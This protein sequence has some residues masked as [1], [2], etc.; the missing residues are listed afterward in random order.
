[1]SSEL[2]RILAELWSGLQVP[3]SM[4]MPLGAART[5]W[6]ELK[7]L[8]KLQ[9]WV[10]AEDVNLAIAKYLNPHY[11]T[12]EEASINCAAGK[13]DWSELYTDGEE[14]GVWCLHCGVT[15]PNEGESL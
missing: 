8:L 9:G 12:E 2:Y 7:E 15:I 1:M 14:D 11:V 4:N 3:I 10:T 5:P 6:D 13:H